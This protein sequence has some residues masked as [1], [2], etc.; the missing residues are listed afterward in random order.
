MVQING[1]LWLKFDVSRN[2]GE[3]PFAS[4]Q[5]NVADIPSPTRSVVGKAEFRMSK[6]KRWLSNSS[7]FP[8]YMQEKGD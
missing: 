4:A 2:C 1:K 8:S 7:N 5:M 6:E 3:I